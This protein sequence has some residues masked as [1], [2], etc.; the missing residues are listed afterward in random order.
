MT[1]CDKRIEVIDDLTLLRNWVFVLKRFGGFP[2][3][4]DAVIDKKMIK[5]L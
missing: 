1:R 5:R 4:V 2:L 3:F